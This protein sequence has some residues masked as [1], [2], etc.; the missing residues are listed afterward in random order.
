MKM[1]AAEGQGKLVS[2]VFAFKIHNA[3]VFS[4]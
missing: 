1:A 2:S 4:L 3:A